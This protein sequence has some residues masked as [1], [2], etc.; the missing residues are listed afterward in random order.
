LAGP[1]LA[2]EILVHRAHPAQPEH[3]AEDHRPAAERDE[4]Q[5]EHHDLHDEAG[6]QH[7]ADDGEIL[8][9][10]MAWRMSLGILRGRKVPVSTQPMRIS[11]SASVSP[12]RRAAWASRMLARPDSTTRTL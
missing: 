12:L 2:L 5:P 3:L 6:M 8:V 4:Q 11:P 9:H 7:Q 10:A 1:E